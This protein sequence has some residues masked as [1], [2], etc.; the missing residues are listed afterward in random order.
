MSRRPG[1]PDR[2]I[3]LLSGVLAAAG[4]A[5]WWRG[6]A[7]PELEPHLWWPVRAVLFGLSERFAVHLPFGRDNHSLTLDQAPLVLGLFFLPL[8]KLMP[9]ALLGIVVAH[10]VLNRIPAIKVTFN[11]ASGLMQVA[12]AALVFTATL[13]LFG[14]DPPELS[15]AT[16]VAA[17]AATMAADLTSNLALFTVISLRQARWDL[18]ELALTLARAAIGT[19]VV[20]DLALVTELLLRRD[21]SALVLLG[22]AGV[23]CVLLY[24]GYHRQRLR[25]GR[26]ELLYRFTRSVEQALRDESVPETV[27]DQACELLR[28]R[29]ARV[30]LRGRLGDDADTAWWAPAA[31][32]TAVRLQRDG[33]SDAHRALRFRRPPGRHGCPL[34]DGGEII[35]VLVVTDRLDDI[36]TFDEDDAR[37]C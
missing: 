11:V 29:H 9:A 6:L 12:L 22:V 32:G 30:L 18:P 20:T 14:A 28:A 17:L 36:S 34:R 5:L 10:T 37:L 4:G 7:L 31:A 19:V 35:G 8:E 2:L 23:L 13:D 27:A 16:G 24:R 1:Q 25:S 33:D 21:T 26:L 3:W 15:P